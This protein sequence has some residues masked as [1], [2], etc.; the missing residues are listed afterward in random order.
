MRTF[1][2]DISNNEIKNIFYCFLNDNCIKQTLDSKYILSEC[3][4]NKALFMHRITAFTIKIREYYKITAAIK[5]IDGCMTYKR[6]LTIIRHICK[7]LKITFT[8]SVVYQ[9]SKYEIVYAID[10]TS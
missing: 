6:F 2:N 1:I 8:N 3:S 10:F 7:H 5:Y 9:S 4:F